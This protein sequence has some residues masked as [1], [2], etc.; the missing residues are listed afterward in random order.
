MFEIATEKRPNL[1]IL[2]KG[3]EV[4]I[5]E[6][7][8]KMLAQDK[9]MQMVDASTLREDGL[10]EAHVK[11]YF[12]I[13]KMCAS[14]VR[15]E[16]P[17]MAKAGLIAAIL[18]ANVY[19]FGILMFEIAIGKCPNLPTLLGEEEVGIV[20]WARKMLAQNKH[21]QMVDASISREGGLIEAHVKEYFEI[22]GMCTS[23]IRRERPTMAKVFRFLNRIPT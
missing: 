12:E 20:K 6:W 11:E 7:A 17:T 23:E 14:E 2:L 21:I 10:I 16:R 18:E 22:A 8:R 1:P 5:V 3:E 13:A 15:R 19:S 9:H 4:G